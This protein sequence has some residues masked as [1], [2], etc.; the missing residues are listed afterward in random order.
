MAAL[1]GQRIPRVNDAR[2]LCGAGRFVDDVDIPR[3]SYAAIV[4]STVAHANVTR[5]DASAAGTAALVM[6]PDE[7]A[8]RVRGGLPVLWV[9]GDQTSLHTP[10]V[11]L[12]VKY[13]GQ[14][15]GVVVASSRALAEDI[16]ES[17][18][19][20]YEDLPVVP[21]IEQALAPGAVLIDESRP[22]NVLAT[23]ECGD[24]AAD[25]SV[26]F[27]SAPRQLR[28]R[29]HIGRLTGVPMEPRGIAVVPDA[30]G[31]LTV[32]TST[33]SAHAVRDGIAEVTGLAQHRIRVIT[34]DVGGG[35]GLK[36]HAYEDELLVVLA[37]LELGTPVKWIED[38]NESL[39]ATTQARD[40]IHDATIA[41]T[42]DGR[43]L[44]LQVESWR[45]VG[46][47]LSIFGGGPLF[48]ALGMM[49][50]PYKWQAVRGVGRLVATNRT[51]TGAYRGFGQT[52]AALIREHM[53]E[54]VARE[55]GV[56]PVAL[57][58][59][60][61]IGVDELPY[62]NRAFITYDNGDYAASLLRA[63]A[64]IEREIAA[65]ATPDDGRRR[66][67]GYC[68][69]V[70]LAGV[71]P[72][73]INQ[74]LGL[75]IGGH[76]GATVRMERDATVRLYV[77]ISP[78]GQGQ[79]TTFAQLVADRLGVAIEDIELIYGDTDVT[80]YSA[81][82]TAASRSIAVGGGAAIVASDRLAT[83]LRAIA[84]EM[85]EAN[86]DDIVLG[87]R[88][89]TVVG[90]NV[91]VDL[92]Q[93]AERANQGFGLPAGIT[94]GLLESHQYDPESATFSYATHACQVAVDT[95]TGVVEVEHYVVVNDCGT[96]VNP[97]IVDGQ[98][99]GG[100]AQGLG[101]ALLEEV[102]FDDN[103]QPLTTTLLDYLLPVESSIPQ[104]VIEHI[105]T[106]SPYTP[107]GMK[108]MGEGG[109]NGAY[110][111]VVN[112]VYAAVPEIGAVDCVTPLSPSR[113]WSLLHEAS[114]R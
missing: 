24:S 100:I 45:N 30:H 79:E 7:L 69:Y 85:L 42:D 89:A 21:D 28:R 101:A 49:P 61:L 29:F 113:L 5:F 46:A 108:G 74:M 95:E 22:G 110:A 8:R 32:Y 81:Y 104:I 58:L 4:R 105:E 98:I 88:R 53:V 78:H 109:T 93:V 26:V 9:L 75:H 94:P 56:D 50:G 62:T 70:Q 2:L 13:V 66:G 18:V 77:G 103:G 73:N 1:V 59:Q 92:S 76:E 36:D 35:F 67:I 10:V 91:A 15:L 55:L 31:K 96:I 37:A 25:T 106:P 43:L 83:K 114:A 71:G 65:V 51:P 27:G 23:L 17:I 48:A 33:Q 80:P 82:G 112:A 11:D 90:T 34:P 54:L 87:H 107:G 47:Q 6:G 68:V 41:F 72:S 99:Q 63:R 52:Q 86:P 14:P 38:R 97:N 44:G 39:I 20:E 57:R 102:V 60:N 64:L 40:E 12:R 84:A 111:C 19:V 3:V 16:A